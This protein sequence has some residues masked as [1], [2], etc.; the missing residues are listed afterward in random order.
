MINKLVQSAIY[1]LKIDIAGILSILSIF[2]FLLLNLFNAAPLTIT[3][4]QKSE[5]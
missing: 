1:L 2:A 3:N 4:N 5:K